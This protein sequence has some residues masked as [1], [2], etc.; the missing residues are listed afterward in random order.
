MQLGLTAEQKAARKLG[1]GGSDAGKIM[2][3]EWYDLWLEKTGQKES[4]DLSDVLPVMLGHAT[5]P[6]NAFWYEKQTGNSVFNQGLSL[7]AKEYSFI[8]CTLDG[9]V[10]KPPVK[11]LASAVWQ[12]KHVSGRE[13]IET[14]IERYTPQVTHEMIV[15]GLNMAVLSVIMGT[16]RYV[17]QEIP[18]D[19]FYAEVL[20]ER[21]REFWSYVEAKKP[22]PDAPKIEAP[23]LIKELRKVDMAS[24]NLWCA[25]A[26][27]WKQH[28]Q[29]AKLF[30]AAEKGLK[31]K[32]EEDVGEASGGGVIVKRDGRGLKIRSA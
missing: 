2:A 11:S 10:G 21:E 19:E 5:E 6:F 4:D 29:A 22:P 26:A 18:L 8:R 27:D 31:A 20:I 12:A 28:Q 30:A 32:V 3:G 16:D 24:D 13:P 15:T 25:L 17:A 14:I 1:I 7:A 9:F 23:K